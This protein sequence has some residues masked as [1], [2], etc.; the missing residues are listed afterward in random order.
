MNNIIIRQI[1][2]LTS[3]NN[4]NNAAHKLEE[5]ELLLYTK[6]SA[7]TIEPIANESDQIH[8][9]NDSLCEYIRGEILEARDSLLVQLEA[10]GLTMSEEVLAELQS[11]NKD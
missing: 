11:T 10:L 4:L 9:V 1:K 5:D 7:N 6:G 3:L 2:L 8:F